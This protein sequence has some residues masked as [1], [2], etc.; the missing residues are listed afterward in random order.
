[1]TTLRFVELLQ[2]QYKG[3]LDE[4]ADK[5]LNFIADAAKRMRI[6]ITDLLDFSRIGTKEN[7]ESVD[8]NLYWI[9]YWRTL[10]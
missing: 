10:W 8:C 9:I 2:M 7:V 5:Y 1:M 6:L 3:K 4:K